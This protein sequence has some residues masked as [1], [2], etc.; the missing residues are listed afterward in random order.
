[1]DSAGSAPLVPVDTTM[2]E[3]DTN[4]AADLTVVRVVEL[5]RRPF[6]LSGIASTP[7]AVDTDKITATTVS[8]AILSVISKELVL[9]TAS[10]DPDTRPVVDK[11]LTV[12]FGVFDA[13]VFYPLG[14]SDIVATDVLWVKAAATADATIVPDLSL[15]GV[16]T[17]VK[18]PVEAGLLQWVT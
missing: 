18:D 8:R 9:G 11:F 5:H 16:F 4:A 1:M 12:P 7:D 14:V 3:R 15:P 17:T 13:F 6:V 10:G 2:P